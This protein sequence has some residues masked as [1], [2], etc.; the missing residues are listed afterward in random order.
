[1]FLKEDCTVSK[2]ITCVC[3]N[4]HESQEVTGDCGGDTCVLNGRGLVILPHKNVFYNRSKVKR[5]SFFYGLSLQRVFLFSW[6]KRSV[7]NWLAIGHPGPFLLWTK[8]LNKLTLSQLSK[9]KVFGFWTAGWTKE[10]HENSTSESGKVWW[11][12]TDIL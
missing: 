8:R 10:A 7:Q 2:I 5:M 1:M 9:W 6:R 4:K 3:D 11:H 12:H